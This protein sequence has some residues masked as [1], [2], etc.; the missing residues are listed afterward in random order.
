MPERPDLRVSETDQPDDEGVQHVLIIE[1]TVLALE[2][3]VVDKIN[4]ITLKEEKKRRIFTKCIAIDA[5]F[6]KYSQYNN[7]YLKFLLC[8]SS[9]D[10]WVLSTFLHI[11]IQ[12][13]TVLFENILF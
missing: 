2:D 13:V 5:A 1:N 6:G 8:R 7:F 3:D 4:K 9:N 10:Q 11:K 12:I